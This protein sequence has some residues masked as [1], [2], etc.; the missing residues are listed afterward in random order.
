MFLRRVKESDLLLF[1]CLKVNICV[2]VRMEEFPVAVVVGWLVANFQIL[3]FR[4]RNEFLRVLRIGDLSGH[5]FESFPD[6][7][8]LD[9]CDS[10]SEVL[11]VFFG[12]E[13][14]FKL[15]VVLI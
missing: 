10:L 11:A 3:Q 4:L 13:I 6:T 9:F 12:V 5:S 8:H 14:W 1:P 15:S 2:P 7:S